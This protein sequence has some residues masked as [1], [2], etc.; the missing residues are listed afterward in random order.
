MHR[1]CVCLLLVV[2]VSVDVTC[3]R[4]ASGSPAIPVVSAPRS[5]LVPPPSSHVPM[6]ALTTGD[7]ATAPVVSESGR[8]RCRL[9]C[10]AQHTQLEGLPGMSAPRMSLCSSGSS[11]R[12]GGLYLALPRIRLSTRCCRCRRCCCCSPAWEGIA[13]L[14]LCSSPAVPPSRCFLLPG[15]AAAA[16]AACAAPAGF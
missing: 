8:L 13:G 2:L 12:A 14:G 9:T 5:R 4:V 11:T 6:A 7:A 1:G 15:A 10:L 16:A 3:Q